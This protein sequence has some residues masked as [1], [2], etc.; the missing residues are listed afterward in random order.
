MEGDLTR[1]FVFC[2][3]PSHAFL[4]RNRCHDI[5]RFNVSSSANQALLLQI[6]GSVCHNCVQSVPSLPHAGALA[7]YY[8]VFHAAPTGTAA[9]I[10]QWAKAIERNT[11]Q[12]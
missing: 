12:G 11:S 3:D 9:T 4:N 10:R 8:V 1:I 6:H 2:R 5:K 7:K